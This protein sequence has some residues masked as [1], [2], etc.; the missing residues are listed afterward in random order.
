MTE[1]AQ[2]AKAS[3]LTRFRVLEART[4]AGLPASAITSRLEA[5]RVIHVQFGEWPE[6][7][8]D[9]PDTLSVGDFIAN[10]EAAG[11]A[12]AIKDGRREIASW[13]DKKTTLRTLRLSAGFSQEQLASAMGTSQSQVARIESG[14]QELTL[15]TLERLAVAL[16]CNIHDV[17]DAARG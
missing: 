7:F 9:H 11:F 17:V 8:V 1:S 15:S 10:L 4:S 3:E 5:S 16:R 14:R 13:I 2:P 6:P 12:D